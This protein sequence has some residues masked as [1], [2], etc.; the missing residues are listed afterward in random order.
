MESLSSADNLPVS[1]GLESL[2]IV[3]YV[4]ANVRQFDRLTIR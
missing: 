4:F 3:K 2:A 1:E